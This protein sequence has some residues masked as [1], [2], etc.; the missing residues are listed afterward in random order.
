MSLCWYTICIPGRLVAQ[1]NTK[2][3]PTSVKEILISLSETSFPSINFSLVESTF[4]WN[5]NPLRARTVSICSVNWR[6]ASYLFSG[7]YSQATNPLM[8][9]TMSIKAI[10]SLGCFPFFAIL[11]TLSTNFCGDS[12]VWTFNVF[13]FLFFLVFLFNHLHNT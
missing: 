12:W 6:I 5:S 4:W 1:P 3:T 2:Y 9:S 8:T 10:C 13:I 7:S 11:Q